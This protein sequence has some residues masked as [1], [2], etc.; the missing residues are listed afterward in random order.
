MQCDTALA[1]VPVVAAAVVSPYLL[2]LGHNQTLSWPHNQQNTAQLTEH[3]CF[4]CC[5]G[6]GG[7]KGTALCPEGG[8]FVVGSALYPASRI[9]TLPNGAETVLQVGRRQYI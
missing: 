9:S 4:L 8:E 3:S 1:A 2:S 7:W 5:S 6:F